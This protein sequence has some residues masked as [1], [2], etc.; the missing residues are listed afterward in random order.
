MWLTLFHVFLNKNCGP[1]SHVIAVF[2]LDNF[3]MN[4]TVYDDGK[5]WLT[6]MFRISSRDIPRSNVFAEYNSWAR[7]PGYS[8][9]EF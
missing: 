6:F 7:Y 1:L 9:R 8:A 4:K 2:L 3:Q 5:R